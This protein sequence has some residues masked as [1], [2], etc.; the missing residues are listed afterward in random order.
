MKIGIQLFGNPGKNTVSSNGKSEISFCSY[1]QVPPKFTQIGIFGMKIC[2]QLF[3]NPGKNL[4][5]SRQKRN[6]FLFLCTNIKEKKNRR[7]FY[8]FRCEQ[9]WRK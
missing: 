9:L 6:F 8:I 2:I 1:V 7:F 3:G 4:I 5:S